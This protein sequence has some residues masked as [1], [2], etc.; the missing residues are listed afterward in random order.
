MLQQSIFHI[1]KTR[2]LFTKFS[3]VIKSIHT[4][5]VFSFKKVKDK[6]LSSRGSDLKLIEVNERPCIDFSRL[7]IIP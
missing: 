1:I 2:S 3:W 7:Q 6:K 4:S 5:V